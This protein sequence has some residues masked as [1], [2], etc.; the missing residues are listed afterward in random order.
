MRVGTRTE[1]GC[2]WGPQGHRPLAPIH[3]GYSFVHLFVALAP[4]TGQVFAMFL[5]ALNQACFGLSGHQMNQ[6]APAARP[7]PAN[8]TDCGSGNGS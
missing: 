5:P 8:V 3:I 2:K 6:T 4:L 1:L 7:E